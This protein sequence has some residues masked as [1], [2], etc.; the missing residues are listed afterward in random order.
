MKAVLLIILVVL[1]HS[2]EFVASQGKFDP[3]IW[4]YF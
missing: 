3:L 4:K 1:A 2:T